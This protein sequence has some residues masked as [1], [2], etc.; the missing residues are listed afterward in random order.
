MAVVSSDVAQQVILLSGP[1]GRRRGEVTGS[2]VIYARPF[3]GVLLSTDAA[4]GG[5]AG[6][7]PQMCGG[8][9]KT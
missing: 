3:P 4:G 1:R 7:A 2:E 8:M 5:H 9:R 6:T